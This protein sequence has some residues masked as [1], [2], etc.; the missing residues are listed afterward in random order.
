RNPLLI[1]VCYFLADAFG[2][3]SMSSNVQEAHHL[4]PN[5]LP[6]A[7]SVSMGFA[8]SFGYLLHLGYSS[9]FG[10]NPQFVIYSMGIASLCFTIVISVF[11]EF[12]GKDN[13]HVQMV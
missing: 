13:T 8:W 2:F 5:H 1:F 3:L 12:F 7:S 9:I 4:L 10:N 11:K 6:F